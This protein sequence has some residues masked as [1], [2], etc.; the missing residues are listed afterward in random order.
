MRCNM[1]LLL[2]TCISDGFI[3]SSERASSTVVQRLADVHVAIII[4]LAF[5][6]FWSTR[7]FQHHRPGFFSAQ[8]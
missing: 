7:R 5:D 3:R 6:K 1:L 2:C 4:L 8:V